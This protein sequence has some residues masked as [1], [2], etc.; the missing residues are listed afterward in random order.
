MTEKIPNTFLSKICLIQARIGRIQALLSTQNLYPGSGE[1]F[2]QEIV[3]LQNAMVKLIDSS[4]YPANQVFKEAAELNSQ[5]NFLDKQITMLEGFA[6][7]PDKVGIQS[8]YYEEISRLKNK[9][10][11][12]LYQPKLKPSISENAEYWDGFLL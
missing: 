7:D 9:L 6:L 3:I 5:V 1:G 10:N 11:S 2:L 4:N 12:L 8:S